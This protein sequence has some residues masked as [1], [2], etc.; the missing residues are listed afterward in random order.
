MNLSEFRLQDRTFCVREEAT[1]MANG[2]LRALSVIQPEP[3]PKPLIQ[4]Q[5]DDTD[6]WGLI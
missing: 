1:A 6:L 5:P 3:Q 4:K 2:K